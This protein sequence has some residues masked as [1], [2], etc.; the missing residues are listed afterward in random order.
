MAL[1]RGII[2]GCTSIVGPCLAVGPGLEQQPGD[3]AMAVERGSVQGC[4]STFVSCV[5]VSPCLEQQPGDLPMALQRCQFQ[6]C[7]SIVV[8]CVAVGPGL[9]QQLDDLALA[10]ARGVVEGGAVNAVPVLQEGPEAGGVAAGRLECGR[11][12]RGPPL[13]A[14][15]VE[16]LRGHRAL[17]FSTAAA[18]LGFLGRPALG[19]LGRPALTG[20]LLRRRC[21]RRRL[22]RRLGLLQLLLP[23]LLALPGGLLCR[24]PL[25]RLPQLDGRHLRRRRLGWRLFF[26]FCF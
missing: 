20:R 7:R 26:F 9:E 4:L 1:L 18:A 16:G 11:H 8:S 22:G 23:E 13:L 12:L 2:Q 3:L 5:A 21:C 19:F 10:V 24:H 15:L 6:G 17:L 14:V 25:F